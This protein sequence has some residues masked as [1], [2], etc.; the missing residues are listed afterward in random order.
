MGE[1]YVAFCQ[2][3][4]CLLNLFCKLLAKRH[5]FSLCLKLFWRFF[6]GNVKL[7]LFFIGQFSVV[8]SV[9]DRT[10]QHC[11][12]LLDLFRYSQISGD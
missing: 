9:V 12:G 5:L 4:V 8:N 11:F 1:V 3:K 10:P 6:I 7:R 2:V